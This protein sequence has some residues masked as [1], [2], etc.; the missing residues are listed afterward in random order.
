[1]KRAIFEGVCT[2]LITPFSEGKINYR[3]L[4]ELIDWQVASGIGA[5]V[6]GGTTGESA[7]L[8][9]SEQ[10]RLIG[11]AVQ[12]TQKRCKII[13]GT[14]SNNAEHALEL[15]EFANSVGADGLLVVT[16]YYNKSN[17]QGLISYYT[18]IAD[19]V[20]IPLI[21]YNVPSRTGVDLSE[22]IYYTLSQHPNI[23]GVKEASGNL[24]KIARIIAQCGD[25][26]PVWSGNDEQ[27]IPIMALG[28]K[29]VISVLSNI[30]PR[31]TLEMVAAFQDGKTQE[32]GDLQCKLME[33]IDA[34]FC[35]VNPIPVKTAMNL[36]G[37]EVGP[38]RAPL[39]SMEP[40]H[41]ARLLAALESLKGN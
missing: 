30:A 12:Y 9:Q 14:G 20:T 26:L 40:E 36:M 3:K 27:T 33:M 2:A 13:A 37:L 28:G 25:Q 5:I 6:I 24:G 41:E 19:R 17:E 29:G 31:K 4:E 21:L 22:H 34:L 16:P 8:S 11:H 10:M 38:T 23:G 15:S 7:T 39:A 18:E 32:A 1:M 35:E